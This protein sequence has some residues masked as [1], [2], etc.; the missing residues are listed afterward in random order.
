MINKRY[1][2]EQHDEPCVAENITSMVKTAVS[3]AT[4]FAGCKTNCQI[5]FGETWKIG[6]ASSINL[7]TLSE[8]YS[9]ND[10]TISCMGTIHDLRRPKDLRNSESTMGDHNNFREY[11]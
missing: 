11:G 10:P 3:S 2:Q 1:Y 7:W 8:M 5:F 4:L 6:L 9:I